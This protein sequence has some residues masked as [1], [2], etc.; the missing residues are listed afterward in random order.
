MKS[1]KLPVLKNHIPKAVIG[2]VKIVDKQLVIYFN[3]KSKITRG[4]LDGLFDIGV[5]IVETKEVK[6]VQ[7]IRQI[8]LAYLSIM[9]E[10]I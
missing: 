3:Y 1:I 6:G 5:E 7:Y 8:R 2:H 4:M 10:K 9:N